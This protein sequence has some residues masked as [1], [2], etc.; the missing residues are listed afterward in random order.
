ME[1]RVNEMKFEKKRYSF[2]LYS[3]Y[4]NNNEDKNDSSN[5]NVVELIFVTN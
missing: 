5:K 2:K 4:N 3:E 1:N